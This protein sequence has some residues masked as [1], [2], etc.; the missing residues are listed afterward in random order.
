V[1]PGHAGITIGTLIRRRFVTIPIGSA[2][3]A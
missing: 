1:E 3:E 2:H